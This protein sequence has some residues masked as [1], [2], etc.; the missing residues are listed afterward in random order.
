M[1]YITKINKWRVFTILMFLTAL[2]FSVSAQSGGTFEIKQ[3]V[4]GGG[5]DG[6]ATGG[7]YSVRATVGQQAR[8]FRHRR[9]LQLSEAFGRRASADGMFS[10][11]ST[12]MTRPISRSFARA[13]ENGG[14][15]IV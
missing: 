1:N 6:Q 4:I 12:A 10:Q 2:T 15:E 13:P 14:F 3:N 8:G 5:T 11:I 7:Q 9:P